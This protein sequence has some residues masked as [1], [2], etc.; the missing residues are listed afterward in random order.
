M[1]CWFLTADD[2]VQALGATTHCSVLAT[3]ATRERG[4]LLNS[5]SL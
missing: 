3:L 4:E 2:S 1:A 5:N